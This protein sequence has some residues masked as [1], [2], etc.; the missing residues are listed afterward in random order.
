MGI[1]D[2]FPHAI[3]I[4]LSGGAEADKSEEEDGEEKS[5][6]KSKDKLLFKANTKFPHKKLITMSRVE[7]LFVTLSYRDDDGN[8]TTPI[9]SF[10]ITGVAAAIERTAKDPTKT[11]VGKPKVSVT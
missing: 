5:S 7:D 3:S 2:A 10:N 6:G 1:T 9:A 4:R 8:P 11:Q